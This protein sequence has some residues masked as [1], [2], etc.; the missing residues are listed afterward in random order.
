MGVR[1]NSINEH[2]EVNEKRAKQNNEEKKKN[3]KKKNGGRGG[4]IRSRKM[5]NMEGVGDN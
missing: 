5:K 2:Q 4:I 1:K 3:N